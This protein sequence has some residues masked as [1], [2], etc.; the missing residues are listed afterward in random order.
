MHL[1]SP[2]MVFVATPQSVPKFPPRRFTPQ[3]SSTK[4]ICNYCKQTG[5]S[6]ANCYKLR[7]KGQSHAPFQ[8]TA[9]AISSSSFAPASY[10]E[11]PSQSSILIA[12]DVEALIHKVLSRSSTALSITS[13]KHSWF[14]NST[15]CN[16]MTP[17]PTLFSQKFTLSSNP[18]IYT[19]D[20]S[21][22]P[23]N[24]IRSISLPNLSVDNTYLVP[25]LSL[26]LL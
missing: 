24:D 4:L 16:H 13:G 10:T 1:Q 8:Q 15:C 23:V 2:N 22:L 14:I 21:R 17:N 12:S 25:L 18:T 6:V 19:A 20:G 26:N 5:H 3:S 7:N 11:N 9:T